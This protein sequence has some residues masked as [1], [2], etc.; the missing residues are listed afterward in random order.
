LFR[1]EWTIVEAALSTALRV[2]VRSDPYGGKGLRILLSPVRDAELKSVSGRALPFE[3]AFK[4]DA[5][6]VRV[7]V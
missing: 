5:E 3:N 4:I 1:I 7:L 2:S 6:G